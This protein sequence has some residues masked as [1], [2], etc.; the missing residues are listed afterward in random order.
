MANFKKRH[1]A[2]R[3]ND[4]GVR[5]LLEKMPESAP[6]IGFGT[7]RKKVS[8]D[9]DAESP[10]VLV[11]AGT[12]G[13]KSVILRCIASQLL[14]NGAHAFVLDYKRISHQWA[15]GV[16]GVTYCRDIADIHQALIRLG[17]E[18]HRRIRLADDLD[19]DADPTAIGPRLAILL[20]EVNATMKQLARYWASIREPG[21][22]KTQ[23]GHRR[24][25]RDPLHGP[26]GP[27]ARPA[28]RP[29]RHR[30]LHRRTRDA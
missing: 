24:P 2:T 20:E 26:T 28:R 13:R 19:E 27:H 6:L 30:P 22:P 9:L 29:V 10:H 5:D 1:H 25:R 21:D 17:A 7:G 15:R 4:P 12:G 3:F 23:P 16:P 14:H 18:G 8:V 11:S